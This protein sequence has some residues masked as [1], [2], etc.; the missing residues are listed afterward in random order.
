MPELP[1][2]ETVRRELEM[3]ILGKEIK[4]IEPLWHRSYEELSAQDVRGQKIEKI[5]RRGKYLF[6]H[7]SQSN[8]IIHLRMTGQLLYFEDADMNE[9]SP[10]VR[11]IISFKDHSV[12]YFHDV[13]KFGRISYVDDIAKTLGHVGPDALDDVVTETYFKDCLNSSSANIKGFLLAQKNVSGIGN[14]YADEAL[15]LAGVDPRSTAK[16]IPEKKKIAL[17]NSVLLVLKRS[18]ENMG[19]TISDYRDPSGNSG[20]NQNYFNVY[21]RGGLECKKCSYKIEKIKHAGRGTH[22][23]PKCQ[24]KY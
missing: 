4:Q 5:G 6:L 9:L 11:V 8:L 19:S 10:Y 22:F 23:C 14:I 21:S 3:L 2:V 13:R 18:V 17:Y 7:L 1:E 20:Q 15:F 16:D 12:L 24:V